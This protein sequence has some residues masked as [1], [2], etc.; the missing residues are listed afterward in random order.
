MPP[1][2]HISLK[3]FN[4]KN[5]SFFKTK[6]RN[7]YNAKKVTIDNKTFDSTS[8]GDYYAQLKLQERAGLIKGVDCQVKEEL[9]AYGK[10][11]CDYKV[12]FLVYHLD[13]SLEYI[14]HKGNPTP[15]WRIK[16]KFLEA[17]YADDKNVKCT[18][19]WYKGYKIRVK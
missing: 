14:E 7:K 9:W 8:E 3:E 19:N 15:D 6:G 1:I 17:K 18:I 2:E 13:G 5:G 16:W 10:H 11:I 4:R 12:D